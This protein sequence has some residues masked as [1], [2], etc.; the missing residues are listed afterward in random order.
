MHR[1]QNG[2]I[3]PTDMQPGVEAIG[4]DTVERLEIR[5]SGS[6]RSVERHPDVRIAPSRAKI[7][8]QQPTEDVALRLQRKMVRKDKV[9]HQIVSK[10][11]KRL[12]HVEIDV[13]FLLPVLLNSGI[14]SKSFQ[15]C[16]GVCG[17]PRKME[18]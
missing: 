12:H 8:L 1:T 5:E 3:P 15:D 4:V 2:A 14:A 16:E 10:L 11:P 6:V 9:H 13:S 17:K 18:V 7:I